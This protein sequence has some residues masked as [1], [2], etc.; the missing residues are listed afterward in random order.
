MC[1]HQEGEEGQ[2][3]AA[4]HRAKIGKAVSGK[5]GS[6]EAC[7]KI[8]KAKNGKKRGPRKN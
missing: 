2:E 1:H 3:E 5:K 7:A 4:E 8:S 6:A